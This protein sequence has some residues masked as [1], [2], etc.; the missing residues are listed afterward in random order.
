MS[1]QPTLKDLL[2]GHRVLVIE[3][4]AVVRAGLLAELAG[5]LPP[6]SILMVEND[7]SAREALAEFAPTLAIVDLILGG[8]RKLGDGL[9]MMEDFSRR[10]PG[11]VMLVYSSVEDADI[12]RRALATGARGYVAKCEPMEN[13]HLALAS[14]LAGKVYLSPALFAELGGASRSPTLAAD[15]RF[16]LLTNRERHVLHATALGQPNRRIAADLGLSVKTVESHKDAL[17]RKLAL[18]SAGEL[19]QVSQTYLTALLGISTG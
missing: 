6:E 4:H 15:P 8:R 7:A 13:L 3:D 11:L 5:A 18:N 14:V 12:A 10:H 16:A 9:S 2:S 17:K 1:S 19:E